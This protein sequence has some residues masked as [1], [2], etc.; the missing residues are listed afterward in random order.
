MK[1]KI[2]LEP[3]DLLALIWFPALILALAYAW[4]A[5]VNIESNRAFTLGCLSLGAVA[6]HAIVRGYNAVGL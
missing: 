6:V 4:G 1:G 5:P 2:K 3:V